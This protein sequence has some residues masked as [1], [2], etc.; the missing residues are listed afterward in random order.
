MC[1]FVMLRMLWKMSNRK[2]DQ[3]PAA[4]APLS[5]RS[6][7]PTRELAP[8]RGSPD[9]ILSVFSEGNEEKMYPR[10]LRSGQGRRQRGAVL[11]QPE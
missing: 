6:R 11:R 2:S 9:V 1:E 4:A 5:H 3:K 7:R 10:L 8:A